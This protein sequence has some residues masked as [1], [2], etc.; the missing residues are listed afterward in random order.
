MIDRLKFLPKAVQNDTHL[1]ALLQRQGDDVGAHEAAGADD[2]H[3]LD[4]HGEVRED[5]KQ[6]YPAISEQ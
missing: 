4:V 1:H 5:R 6:R 2:A 3:G